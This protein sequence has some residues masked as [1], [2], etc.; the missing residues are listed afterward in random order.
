MTDHHHNQMCACRAMPY[1]TTNSS[2]IIFSI[3]SVRETDGSALFCVPFIL[4]GTTVARA[5]SAV[6]QC[7]M[8]GKRQLWQLLNFKEVGQWRNGV[9]LNPLQCF[10]KKIGKTFV[11]KF[12]NFLLRLSTS[13]KINQ[14][15]EILINIFPYSKLNKLS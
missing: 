10:Q 12:K 3:N 7:D 8:R 13:A 1:D 2:L 15:Q 6:N 4:N 9:S 5:Q 14:I 11:R